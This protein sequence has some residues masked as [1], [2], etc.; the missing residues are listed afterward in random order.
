MSKNSRKI[1]PKDHADITPLVFNS[2]GKMKP[3]KLKK[4]DDFR[5]KFL[6]NLVE[7]KH[8]LEMTVDYLVNGQKEDIG[9]S[10]SDDFIDELDRA[11]REIYTQ[12]YYKFLDR[13]KKE[14][15]RIDILIERVQQEQ[16]FGICEE[17]GDPIPEGRLLIIPEAVLCVEC[18]EE[19]EKYEARINLTNNN[20]H[21]QSK[22]DYSIQVEDDVDDD[23]VLLKPDSERMS[24]MDLDEIELEDIPSPADT[25]KP[26]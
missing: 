12:S 5:R 15:K 25:E 16:D 1:Q 20:A 3:Q 10:S 24:L 8:E 13:K 22:Y 6:K 11:D 9:K 17:C 19:L 4:S 26:V 14:L 7:K 2:K 23:G 21:N 18:Q